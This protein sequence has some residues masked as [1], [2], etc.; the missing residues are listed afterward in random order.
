MGRRHSR[1]LAVPASSEAT[2]PVRRASRRSRPA[3]RPMSSAL[4][5]R[6]RQQHASAP[7]SP[8]SA[9]P[10]TASV[11]VSRP[12]RRSTKSRE[13]D[14]PRPVPLA[15][16]R[17][18]SS[19]RSKRSK[20]RSR[21]GAGTP[22]PLSATESSARADDDSSV[23]TIRPP[24]G[25]NLVGVREQVAERA[26]QEGRIDLRDERRR[27]FERQGDGALRT[28]GG[29]L[30]HQRFAPRREIE[31]GVVERDAVG[32]QAGQVEQVVDLSQ[33]HRAVVADAFQ[34]SPLGGGQV[35]GGLQLTSGPDDQCERCAQFV[36]D[37]LEEPALE[38][39]CFLQL[40]VER[41]E[42]CVGAF[43]FDPAFFRQARRPGEAF[44]LRLDRQQP[45]RRGDRRERRRGFQR[46]GPPVV[47]VPHGPHF[48]E[49]RPATKRR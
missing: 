7:R 48:N 17:I 10:R 28:H 13:I 34:R 32:L 36:T 25:V 46:A 8:N 43:E 5:T 33:Q 19:P 40:F 6:D 9:P 47:G 14:N 44:D 4:P 49:V 30:R 22:G 1:R 45:D 11:T 20:I 24:S 29:E 3:R 12:P 23:A 15:R 38:R 27:R 42:L 2:G 18:D 16:W 26:G 31:F 21:C 39:V 41:R 35:V 37:V